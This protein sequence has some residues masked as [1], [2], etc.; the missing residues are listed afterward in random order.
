MRIGGQKSC[1]NIKRTVVTTFWLFHEFVMNNRHQVRICIYDIIVTY[2]YICI[3]C[4]RVYES[5]MFGLSYKSLSVNTL[6][7]R[8]YTCIFTC[9]CMCILQSKRLMPYAEYCAN[10]I[11]A[12]QTLEVKK[13]EPAFQDFLQ[14][15]C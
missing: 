7:S 1:H 8:I 14:V 6:S 12:K 2:T 4:F 15:R 11:T 5:L 9:T 10:L 13:H 3:S